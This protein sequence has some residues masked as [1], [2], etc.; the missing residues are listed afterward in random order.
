MTMI[1]TVQFF[2]DFLAS[3]GWWKPGKVEKLENHP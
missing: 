3:Q 2:E 1:G